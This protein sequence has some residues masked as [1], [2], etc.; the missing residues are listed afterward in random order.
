MSDRYRTGPTKHNVPRDLAQA[1]CGRHALVAQRI[2]PSTTDREVRSSNLLESTHP[3]TST[4]GVGRTTHHLSVKGTHMKKIA[5]VVVVAALAFTLTGCVTAPP[6]PK[7]TVFETQLMH[8]KVKVGDCIA[9]V[10]DKSFKTVPCDQSHSDEVYSI[11]SFASKS[12]KAAG[13]ALPQSYSV[14]VSYQSYLGGELPTTTTAA[15]VVVPTTWAISAFSSANRPNLWAKGF[16]KAI[17]TV[18][19]DKLDQ[20]VGSVKGTLSK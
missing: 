20:Q 15:G 3:A 11:V 9:A 17:F 19:T 14:P 7:L 13:A 10:W 5:A 8:S 1:W 6:E 16:K 2:E 18:R 4:H 12:F